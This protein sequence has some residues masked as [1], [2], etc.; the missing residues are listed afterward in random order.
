MGLA[1]QD[2]G[3]RYMRGDG[4]VDLDKAYRDCCRA[5][6]LSDG[7]DRS[8]RTAA[9]VSTRGRAPSGSAAITTAQRPASEMQ[10]K[11]R[12]PKQGIEHD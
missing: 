8:R 1:I 6:G 2:H 3:E 5:A 11:T 10:S 7:H 9:A 12:S 4:N